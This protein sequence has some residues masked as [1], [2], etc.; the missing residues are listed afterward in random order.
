MVLIDAR[1]GLGWLKSLLFGGF[2]CWL[3]FVEGEGGGVGG[4]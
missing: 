4:N 2:R 1:C 3:G